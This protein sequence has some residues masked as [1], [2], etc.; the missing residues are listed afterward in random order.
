MTADGKSG[1]QLFSVC[2]RF[3][4]RCAGE[5]SEPVR[6]AGCSCCYPGIEYHRP[7][8]WRVPASLS[9]CVCPAGRC[10]PS[11]GTPARGCV[12][13]TALRQPAALRVEREP[14]VGLRVFQAAPGPWPTC[15]PAT[16]APWPPRLGWRVARGRSVCGR[17]DSACPAP[18]RCWLGSPGMV[19]RVGGGEDDCLSLGPARPRRLRPGRVGH[20]CCRLWSWLLGGVSPRWNTPRASGPSTACALW[21]DG[22][23]RGRPVPPPWPP[24]PGLARRAALEAPRRPGTTARLCPVL[25]VLVPAVGGGRWV[26][27]PPGPVLGTRLAAPG[28][29]DDRGE[30]PERG[31]AP[32]GSA[33]ITAVVSEQA[34]CEPQ[35]RCLEV[36]D[37]IW[38]GPAEVA[39]RFVAHLGDIQRGERPRARQAGQLPG[40]PAIGVDAVTGLGGQQRGGRAPAGGVFFRQRAVAPGTTRAGCRDKAHRVGLRWHVAHAWLDGT[41]VGAPGA[42]GGHRSA[43][44]W[45]DIRHGSRLFGDIHSAKEC[46]S[47]GHGEPPSIQVMMRHQAALVAGKL[48]RVTSGVNL[49]AAIGS[50]YVSAVTLRSICLPQS[51]VQ[52]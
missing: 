27:G 12:S 9:A 39:H 48:T 17:V 18:A 15:T 50:H 13:A 20:G 40:V 3:V 38:P 11:R 5:A 42:Q 34:G 30:P 26:C 31:R 14:L 49:P 7:G 36:A 33:R 52:V 23:G 29:P 35:L 16:L 45:G 24:P 44:L 37:G 43:V 1:A 8:G 22:N 25:G 46:A 51:V 2:I 41:L 28:G 6:G 47:L 10:T 19:V 32:R 21:G 4:V